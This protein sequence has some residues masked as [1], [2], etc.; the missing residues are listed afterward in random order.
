MTA[1]IA[2]TAHLTTHP[3]PPPT[4]IPAAH[5]RGGGRGWGGAGRGP[6]EELQRHSRK[7]C[8]LAATRKKS[9]KMTKSLL[10]LPLTAAVTTGS[11]SQSWPE[12]LGR[13]H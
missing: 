3:P 8:G 5:L 4:P 6:G 12:E 7:K 1:V 11:R 9:F 2:R 10:C 13:H